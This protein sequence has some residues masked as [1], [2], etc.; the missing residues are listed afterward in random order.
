MI[1]LHFL[2]D[3]FPH[4]DFRTRK[5]NHSKLQIIAISLSDAGL[6]YL[7]GYWFFS[8]L[9]PLNYLLTAMF[10]SQLP[11]W[12]EAPYHIFNWNFPPFSSIKHFQSRLHYKLGL[13]W[14]LIGQIIAVGSLIYLAKL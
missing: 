11:D 10:I 2:A 12:L 7:L 14:G 9:V 5:S 13:P 6:G 1:G 8:P 4:W 3:I